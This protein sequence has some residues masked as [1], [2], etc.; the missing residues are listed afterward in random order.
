MTPE[1]EKNLAETLSRFHDR[2][3]ALERRVAEQGR[4]VD[5]HRIIGPGHSY[6]PFVPD[7]E[8]VVQLE[9]A[10]AEF[11]GQDGKLA[12]QHPG[13]GESPQHKQSE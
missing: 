4:V 13:S 9:E 1:A 7:P 12:Y 3:T 11:R 10:L 6:E 2:L 8:Q 5:R